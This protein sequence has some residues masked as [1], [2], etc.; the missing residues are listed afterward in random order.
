M[1]STQAH[2]CNAVILLPWGFFG[3]LLCFLIA[4]RS[5]EF[6]E[7]TLM[8]SPFLS[9]STALSQGRMHPL[10][11]RGH[12]SS[13]LCR[14]KWRRGCEGDTRQRTGLAASKVPSQA[15]GDVGAWHLGTGPCSP[16][17]CPSLQPIPGRLV[18]GTPPPHL[19]SLSPHCHRHLALPCSTHLQPQLPSSWVEPKA[20]STLISTRNRFAG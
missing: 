5:A 15:Q 16:P 4:Q 10:S 20:F 3:H 1:H 6:T 11:Q 18:P 8:A 13:S 17:S 12:F 7:V 14:P 2:W 19:S 9:L